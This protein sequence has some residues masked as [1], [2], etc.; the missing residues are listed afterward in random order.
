M[1]QYDTVGVHLATVPVPASPAGMAFDGRHLWVS[2]FADGTLTK[3]RACD[4][5]VIDSFPAG[6]GPLG[7]VFDGRSIWVASYSE[8]QLAKLNLDGSLITKIP[9]GT[10][11]TH[12]AFDG[13]NLWAVDKVGLL[14]KH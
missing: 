1:A 2:S 9:T 5:S 7:V 10:N 3:L 12:L 11:P 8:G 13:A 4:G 6:N 14:I